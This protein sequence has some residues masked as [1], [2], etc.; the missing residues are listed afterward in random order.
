[1][2]KLKCLTDDSLIQIFLNKDKK[3]SLRGRD[4]KR[5]YDSV[6]HRYVIDDDDQREGRRIYILYSIV[7]TIVRIDI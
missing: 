3:M 6:Y 2:K 1:M 4:S 5:V 7:L